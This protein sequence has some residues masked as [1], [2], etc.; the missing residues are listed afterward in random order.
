MLTNHK[1][2]C[3]D[4]NH[5]LYDV[6]IKPLQ[7][8]ITVN[9]NSLNTHSPSTQ[10]L[11]VLYYRNSKS[12]GIKA[13]SVTALARPPNYRKCHNTFSK[14]PKTEPF[15][16]P[17]CND[18]IYSMLF[19]NE[20]KKKNQSAASRED[21]FSSSPHWLP[22]QLNVLY[23]HLVMQL[24]AR[25]ITGSPNE[26]VRL[27]PSSPSALVT[28]HFGKSAHTPPVKHAS[29]SLSLPPHHHRHQHQP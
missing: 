16:Q 19:F 13:D 17:L 24:Q 5:F 14:A 22:P 28:W 10:L 21:S 2:A 11:P 12:I 25:R 27:S 8:K 3:H 18:N 20:G 9:W 26:L 23:K 7:N 1:S 4:W 29:L 15:T 6:L